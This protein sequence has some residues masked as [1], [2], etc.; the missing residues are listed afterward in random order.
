MYILELVIP[1]PHSGQ[2]TQRTA[3]DRGGGESSSSEAGSYQ[4]HSQPR[5][6][7]EQN[8][9]GPKKRWLISTGDKFEATECLHQETP[10]QDGRDR[11]AQGSA[12]SLRLDV[13]HRHQCVSCEYLPGT[14]TVPSLMAMYEFACLPFGLSVSQGCLRS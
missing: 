2:V 7:R 11:N 3:V 6:V 9:F 10:F 12:T 14:L 1:M 13:F 5:P 4:G 8:L